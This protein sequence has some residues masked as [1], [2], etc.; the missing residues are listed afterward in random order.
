MQRHLDLTA[1]LDLRQTLGLLQM[2]ARDPAMRF[3][4]G[5]LDWA[6]HSAAGPVELALRVVPGGLVAEAWGEGAEHALETLEDRLGLRDDPESF[7]P[8]RPALRRLAARFAGMRLP[9]LCR[10]AEVMVPV[11]L[12]QLVTG[13]EAER[14]W[15]GLVREHGAPA[16][17]PAG[18]RL[19][20]E[21][22]AL[23]RLSSAHLA[24][25]GALGKHA[26]TIHA[27]GTHVRYVEQSLA[28]TTHE[29]VAAHLQKLP[30]IGPWTAGVTMLRGMGFADAVPVGDF[31]IPNLVAWV[32]AGEPRAD[33]RRML[34]LLAP[35]AP[36]RGRLVR[37]LM[38]SGQRAPAYGPRH[39]IRPLSEW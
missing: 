27:I 33:D 38:Q 29:E 9:R 32:L 1:P 34:E 26:R 19:P 39:R 16:P 8:D 30:G 21:A 11:V 18:L 15:S 37:Q 6:F 7:A 3:R 4:E 31:H 35:F 17:G 14:A 23:G 5:G 22:R 24:A 2:G 25:V 20:P 10:I 13:V 28:L 12:G 36:H